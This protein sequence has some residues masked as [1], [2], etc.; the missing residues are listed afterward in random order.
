[1]NKLIFILPLII[2]LSALSL[3]AQE[4]DKLQ[5]SSVDQHQVV[6][7]RHETTFTLHKDKFYLIGG[8]ESK[9]VEVFDPSNNT[10]KKLGEAPF[11]MH[12][13]QGVS[14]QDKIYFV[15]AMK[16]NYPTE[17]PLEHIWTYQPEK[18]E[19]KKEGI[20][21]KEVRRGGGGAVLYQEKI[22]LACGITNGHTS[23][24]SNRFDVYDLKSKTW[25][26]L[27]SA[28]HLRDHFNAIVANDKLYL[29]GGRNSSVHHK[30]NFTAFFKYTNLFVDVYDFK[31]QKWITLEDKLPYPSAA[32]GIVKLNNYLIYMGGENALPKASNK[33]QVFDITTEKWSLLPNMLEGRHGTNAILYKGEVY[34]FGGSPVRGGGRVNTMERLG[35]R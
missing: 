3:K 32:G 15:G 5:W 35:S 16:G 18:N 21:P 26:Q 1:M 20:I 28:P 31:T 33:T 17:T 7:G 34:V 24:C 22:Y 9:A 11:F 10:W 4:L 19:W 23:G 2:G 12:H 8:R 13:F 6:G 25:T 30:N 14:Y 29:I 27:T